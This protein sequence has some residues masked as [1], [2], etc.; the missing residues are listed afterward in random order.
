[1]GTRL[2]LLGAVIFAIGILFLALSLRRIIKRIGYRDTGE[3]GRMPPKNPRVSFIILALILIVISQAFF[4][5]SSQITYYRPIG[6]ASQIGK[7]EIERLNDPVKSLRLTY[8]PLWSDSTALP[9]QFYLS[10]DSWKF[11]GEIIKFKFGNKYLDL[12]LRAYK[13]KQ[14]DSRFIERLPPNAS[15]AL[16]DNNI[17]EGG[18]STAFRFFRDTRYFKWFAEVDSFA[19]DYVTTAKV[20]SFTIKL[21]ADRTVGLIRGI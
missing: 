20:D 9:N 2:T 19:T 16:L 11:S 7:L 6:N 3:P 1:M 14:F 8:M 17:L 15:G 10:G 5:L 4:W 21:E 13:I 12:P 18:G